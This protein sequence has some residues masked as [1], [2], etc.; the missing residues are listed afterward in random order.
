MSKEYKIEMTIERGDDEL[1]IEVTGDCSPGTPDRGTSG[2]PENYD[3]GSNAEVDITKI[4]VF[5]ASIARTDETVRRVRMKEKWEGELTP[6]E[7]EEAKDLLLQAMD[8]DDSSQCV[9]EPEDD[10]DDD[11]SMECEPVGDF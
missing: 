9:D 8:E 3:P 5:V 6:K 1:D 2:P 11:S 4:M 10:Y 7:E